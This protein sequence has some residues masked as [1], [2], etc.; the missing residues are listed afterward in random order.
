MKKFCN[1]FSGSSATNELNFKIECNC[2]HELINIFENP[3]QHIHTIVR[4][5]L[6]AVTI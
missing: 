5:S 2:I 3:A 6:R 4:A 1:T